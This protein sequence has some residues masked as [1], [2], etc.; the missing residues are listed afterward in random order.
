MNA[1]PLAEPP[2]RCREVPV[3]DP[4]RE[5]ATREINPGTPE[6]LSRLA[7]WLADVSGEAALAQESP[8]SGDPPVR[9]AD[10]G[11]TAVEATR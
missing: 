9:P 5:D 2:Q 1:E 10:A 6:V 11:S 7:L 3:G 8:E 4:V